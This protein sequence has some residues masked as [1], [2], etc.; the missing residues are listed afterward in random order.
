MKILKAGIIEKGI[1]RFRC[2]SCGCEFEADSS[3][4]EWYSICNGAVA[5]CRCP[6]CK[7]MIYYR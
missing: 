3:E 6:H 1:K 2:L 7:Q 5:R 4:Y